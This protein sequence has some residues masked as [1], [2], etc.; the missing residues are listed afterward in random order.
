MGEV[1][2][3]ADGPSRESPTFDEQ[4]RRLRDDFGMRLRED[5]GPLVHRPQEDPAL[6]E[7]LRVP[8]YSL[9]YNAN[10]VPEGVVAQ[11]GRLEGSLA[12]DV[13]MRRA[14]LQPA[15]ARSRKIATV[16]CSAWGED[17]AVTAIHPLEWDDIALTGTFAIEVADGQRSGD[18]LVSV[19]GGDLGAVLE[20]VLDMIRPEGVGFAISRDPVALRDDP[21]SGWR[22]VHAIAPEEA[23]GDLAE[24]AGEVSLEVLALLL[25]ASEGSCSPL[26]MVPDGYLDVPGIDADGRR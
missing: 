20:A 7:A 12:I 1:A 25:K 13:Q 2:P 5:F 3:S 10:V 4:V 26:T 19:T 18:S 23:T 22:W 15:L 24:L 21:G 9:L 6:A 16:L 17:G 8:Y 11:R 14:G